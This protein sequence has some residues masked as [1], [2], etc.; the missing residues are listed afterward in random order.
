MAVN[1][2]I[3]LRKNPKDAEA[4]PK[5]YATAQTLGTYSLNALAKRIAAQSTVSRADVNAVISS[6]VDNILD[7]LQEGYQADLGE[8]GKLRLHII[9]EGAETLEAFT[10]DNIKAVNVRFV[11]GETL[12]NIFSTLEFEPVPTREA[13]RKV[14][15]AQKAGSTVVDLEA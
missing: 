1:Y 13:T 9:S 11:P 6:L 5:A 2:S 10:S 4:V 7:V 14:L 12:K 15:K 3:S 8:L